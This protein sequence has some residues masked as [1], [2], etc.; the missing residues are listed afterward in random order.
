MV[1]SPHQLLLH[2]TGA[3]HTGT[4]ESP[5]KLKPEVVGKGRRKEA[6]VG[7]WDDCSVIELNFA[8]GLWTCCDTKDNLMKIFTAHYSAT[9]REQP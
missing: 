4:S 5:N 9:D 8:V 3:Q 6:T 2:H 7:H 1:G